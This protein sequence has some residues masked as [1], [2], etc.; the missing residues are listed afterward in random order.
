MKKDK[1]EETGGELNSYPNE[2][3]KK[4]FD[5][6]PEIETLDISQWK[7]VHLLAYFCKKYK[8]IYNINYSWKFNNP[9][10]SK[11]FEVWQLNT[12]SSK[13]SSNPKILKEYIDWAFENVA[14]KSKRRLTSISFMT[15]DPVVSNY[16]MKYLFSNKSPTISRTLDLPTEYKNILVN[17]NI[18]TYGDLAFVYQMTDMPDNIKLALNKLQE[19]G[20]DKSILENII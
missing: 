12:L 16:K 1:I 19:C 5:K 20:F 10:P 6:F 4:F 9:S 3:Y 18:N 2:K 14:K 13:L 8:N 17:L 11:C 7:V 15:S